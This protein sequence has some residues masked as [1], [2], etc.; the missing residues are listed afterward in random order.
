MRKLSVLVATGLAVAGVAW[1]SGNLPGSRLDTPAGIRIEKNEV[2]PYTRLDRA[3]SSAD[4]RFAIVT[5]RTGGHRPKIFS[6][7]ME[8]INQMQPDFVMSVGDLIEGYTEKPE[9][10]DQ[11]WREFQS[12]VNTLEMPFF[13]VPGNHDLTN[14]VMT[15]DYRKRI[16]KPF[17]SFRV[18]TSL[19]LSLS[20]EDNPKSGS[21]GEQQLEM[22]RKAI[23]DNPG[24]AWTFVFIHRPL[25]IE[26]DG[27]KNGW[28]K[29]EEL[30]KGRNYTV[31]CGHEHRYQKFV[32]QGMNYYQLATTG[33]G[34]RLRGIDY[35]EFDQIVWVTMTPKGPSI[36]NV[37]LEGI[38][39]EDLHTPAS[40]ESGAAEPKLPEGVHPVSG[41]VTYKGKPVSGAEILFHGEI[42]INNKVRKFEAD[43]RTDA[44]GF[45]R[46][47]TL[48]AFD[49]AP[50]LDYKVTISKIEWTL[51]GNRS[52]NQ[53]PASLAKPATTPLTA[54]VKPG[55]NTLDFEI[56][57]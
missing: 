25:W 15:E 54:T 12:Y 50:A 7:A 55:S 4:F 21:V 23:E 16:G 19:F 34:S 38:L 39:P 3:R 14:K 22:V 45:Y 8:R 6:Q 11:Q 43:A 17:Y 57:D 44:S 46:L 13:Y 10:I 48:K 28:A 47:S 18:G 33:G 49:G 51:E 24:S 52:P 31:F 1:I 53:L 20:S 5:D 35:G 2:N 32:R 36:A 9:V 30:L 56:R 42:T 41:T 27:Q 37:L 26:N 40:K 29:V